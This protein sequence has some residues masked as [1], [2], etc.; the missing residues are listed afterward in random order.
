MVKLERQNYKKNKRVFEETRD[1]LLQVLGEDTKIDHVG[2][3]AI[4]N[5]WGKNI[6]DILIGAKNKD[7]FE[8]MKIKIAGM[9][10][11][12]SQNSCDE[13]YQFCA[14]KMGETSSG[15]IHLHLVIVDTER[16]NDFLILRDYL[17]ENK[18]EAKNYY[19]YKKKLLDQGVT[20]RKLYRKEKS[21]YVA[22]LIKRARDWYDKRRIKV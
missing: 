11:Y 6:I 7:D 10:Y 16:Y 1:K 3:T 8:Q 13:I 12:L 20:D 5:M 14:S 17:R 22:K 2:S 9:G 21:E 18:D 4:K 19:Q 15:D